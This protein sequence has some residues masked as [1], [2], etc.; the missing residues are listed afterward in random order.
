MWPSPSFLCSSRISLA[1]YARSG[2]HLAFSSRVGLPQGRDTSLSRKGPLS[3]QILIAQSPAAGLSEIDAASAFFARDSSASDRPRGS[4][5]VHPEQRARHVAVRCDDDS[6]LI[7]EPGTDAPIAASV[8][9]ISR[10]AGGIVGGGGLAVIVVNASL[11]WKAVST[12]VLLNR[13]KSRHAGLR[14][15]PRDRLRRP[16]WQ[17][18]SRCRAAPV[19]ENTLRATSPLIRAVE[20]RVAALMT[21]APVGI[22]TVYADPRAMGAAAG[23]A[24]YQA[25]FRWYGR[26]R[27]RA[28]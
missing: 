19:L 18:M 3:A 15:T 12:L 7:G 1:R 16:R 17:I 8:E 6:A 23:W 22:G 27:K 2:H 25:Y 4:P 9:R 21:G 28:S 24:T 10:V 14:R 13:A 5:E 26:Q 11:R 20:T